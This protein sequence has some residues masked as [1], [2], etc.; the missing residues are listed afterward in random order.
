MECAKLF[1]KKFLSKTKRKQQQSG[2]NSSLQFMNKVCLLLVQTIF[3]RAYRTHRKIASSKVF[4]HR[5]FTFSMHIRITSWQFCFIKIVFLSFSLSH[6]CCSALFLNKTN[7][8]V[9]VVIVL[10]HKI[11]ETDTHR[12]RQKEQI[13]ARK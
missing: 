10:P 7:A 13:F 8:S 11:I 2:F 9:S 4:V 1:W 12:E 6:F 3:Q 5:W